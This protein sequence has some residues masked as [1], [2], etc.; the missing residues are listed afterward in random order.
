[1]VCSESVSADRLTELLPEHQSA[2]SLDE[3]EEV[4]AGVAAAPEG[5]F[6]LAAVGWIRLIAERPRAELRRMLRDLAADS[7]SAL[8]VGVSSLR[9]HGHRLHALRHAL[10]ARDLDGFIVPHADAHQSEQLSARDERLAW[11]TGFTG[12]A[13][14]A[15]V[16]RDRAALFIDGRYTVQAPKQVDTGDW[17]LHHLIDMPAAEWIAANLS[18]DDRFGFD[19]WLHTPAQVEGLRSACSRAGARLVAVDDNPLDGIWTQRPKPP[20]APIVVHAD[21]FAGRSARQKREE[22]AE[23]LRRDRQ[24]AV[25]LSAPDDIAWLLNIRGS[26]VPYSPVTLAFAVLSGDA[27]V[28]LFVDPRKLDRRVRQHLGNAVTVAPPE[29]FGAALDHLGDEH[30]RV[31]YVADATPEWVVRRLKA[32]GAEVVAGADPC[33]L[34]KARKQAVELAGIRAAHR[35]DGASLCQFLRWLERT[36]EHG[37][38]TEIQAADRLERFRRARGCYRGPSFAT[39][40]A[41]GPNGAIVHYRATAASDRRLERDTLY[42]VDSGG[43]YLD[44][45]TDVT[46]TIAIGRPSDEMRARFTRVL[47]GHVA[48]ATARFPR[49]TTGPQIDTLARIA[50]WQAG[51]DYDHGTGHGVG[52]YLNVHEGPQRIAKLP[53]RV[54][55]DPG[56][57]VSNEPG[58]YKTGAYGIRIENLITVVAVAAPPGGERDLLGFETLT[59]VPLDRTLV[60]LGLLSAG[61]RAWIDDYHARVRTIVGPLLDPETARWLAAATRPLGC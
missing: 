11:L 32:A 9:D 59:L 14:A 46:R 28:T 23:Q 38:T 8:P 27:N 40:S 4:A 41:A 58:Y 61:E 3:V 60:D 1:M 42:L 57:V 49:G 2:Y 10:I 19:P 24:D 31:R 53:N 44:G 15:V 51:L 18:V 54:A 12:S 17:Q 20:F 21:R 5:P 13:G 22:V 29:T 36:V 56:M 7:R 34:P 48:I 25:V 47:K 50:L 37:G 16:L 45:T 30:R 39:I 52:H 6:G 55:L 26:E 43:Q 33:A 35:R